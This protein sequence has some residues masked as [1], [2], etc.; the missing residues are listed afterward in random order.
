MNEDELESQELAQI[1]T[2]ED[3]IAYFAKSGSVSK[4]K[5]HGSFLRDSERSWLRLLYANRVE[6]ERFA[7]YELQVVAEDK[8]FAF[9]KRC[10]SRKRGESGILHDFGHRP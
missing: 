2:G 5:H 6:S 1:I 9:F 8:A 7:P 3:A 10:F 4:T